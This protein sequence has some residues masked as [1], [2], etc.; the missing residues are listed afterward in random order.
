[1]HQIKRKDVEEE[2]EKK[3]MTEHQSGANKKIGWEL[4][5]VAFCSPPTTGEITGPAGK[6]PGPPGFEGVVPFQKPL[7]YTVMPVLSCPFE[8]RPAPCSVC[9]VGINVLSF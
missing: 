5:G 3:A 9:P 6:R 7:D 2:I 1:M 4:L 8:W